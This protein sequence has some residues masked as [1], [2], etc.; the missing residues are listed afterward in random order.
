MTNFEKAS[1]SDTYA[2]KEPDTSC[3]AVTKYP[4]PYEACVSVRHLARNSS[5]CYALQGGV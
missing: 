2:H 4:V 5:F 1:V 3:R